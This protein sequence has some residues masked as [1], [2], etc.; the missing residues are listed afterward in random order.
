MLVFALG[1]AATVAPFTATV[2][3]SV[4]RGHSG[5][6]SGVNNAV[7]RVAGLLAIAALGA[8]VSGAFVARLDH[9]LTGP[10]LTPAVREAI[11]AARTKPLT[12]HVAGGTVFVDRALT[13]ASVHAFHLVVG[14]AGG[15]AMLG[16]LAALVGIRNPRRR[17]SLVAGERFDLS[18]IQGEG[19]VAEVVAERG[20]VRQ[21]QPQQRR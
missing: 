11:A 19:H 10:R 6:A 14:I 18:G 17:R 9:E 5:L 13:D 16:G 2:L 20:Q 8:V 7:A 3:A 4:E 21:R 12:T 15:L 1:M